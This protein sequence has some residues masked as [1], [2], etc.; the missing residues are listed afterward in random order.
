M[1]A[2]LAYFQSI[3]WSARL[4]ED[5]D[6]VITPTYSR[7]YKASTEDSLF[8]ET[9][10]TEDTIRACLSFYKQQA[11]ESERID[12]VHTLLSLGHGV[13]G[14]PRVAHGGIIATI[15]DE[16]MGILIS[17]NKERGLESTQGDT[18]TAYLHVNY[19]KPVATPQ[20]VLVSAKFREIAGR[21]HYIDGIVKDGSGTVLITAEALWIGSHKPIGK[22]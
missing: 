15:V 11:V 17:I 6:I 19:L 10:K 7:E 1:R 20:A 3:P 12:A 21:K 8:A 22:L 13:N 2:D 5:S 4:L 16:V 9:L 18:V 14:Y